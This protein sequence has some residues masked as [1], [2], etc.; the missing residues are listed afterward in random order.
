MPTKLETFLNENKI[1]PRRL[2]AT[3]RQLERL[4]PEDRAIKLKQAQARRSEDAKKPEDLGKPRSG[5][6]ITEPTL[7]A[8]IAGQSVAGPKKTRILRAV[9]A[10]LE[11]RKKDPVKLHDIFDVPPLNPPKPKPEEPAEGEAAEGEAAEGE[12][13]AEG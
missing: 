5:K 2:L 13:K 12:E 7:N 8:A 11:Q 9:N 4:R 1:D 10:V 3:S 6:P